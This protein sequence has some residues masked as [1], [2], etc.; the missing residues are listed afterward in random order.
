MR[1]KIKRRLITVSIIL[2]LFAMTC[3]LLL[4]N[5]KENI[6]FFATPTELIKKSNKNKTLVRLGGIVA[7]D[8]V[9]IISLEGKYISFKVHDGENSI[10]V[11]YKG[12]LP[13]LFKEGQGVVVDGQY[14][15]RRKV[16]V[17]SRILVKHD[18]VYL[19]SK[20]YQVQ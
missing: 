9:Q 16:F 5:F 19:P 12:M 6:L 14:N 1:S 17:A 13:R 2:C 8:S 3:Y 20:E 7:E 18:E 4:S 11:F 10:V 15:I